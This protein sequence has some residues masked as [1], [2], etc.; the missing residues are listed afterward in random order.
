V[1]TIQEVIMMTARN[2]PSPAGHGDI[3]ESELLHMLQTL[4]D[5]HSGLSA[6]HQ[7]LDEAKTMREIRARFAQWQASQHEH[8]G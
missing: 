8:G 4:I 5:A 6:I 2:L 7:L 1:S 3:V